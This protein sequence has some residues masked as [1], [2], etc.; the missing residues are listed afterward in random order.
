MSDQ[1]PDKT[2]RNILA[3]IAGAVTGII[4]YCI[5]AY[6]FFFIGLSAWP[7]KPTQEEAATFQSSGI[8][9]II[10]ITIISSLVAGLVTS[11]IAM[12]KKITVAAITGFV[13]M[14]AWL[15]ITNLKIYGTLDTVVILILIPS[16]ILGGWL[17]VNYKKKKAASN[18]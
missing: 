14:L 16:A 18:S 11:I 3:V 7:E 4:V 6:I 8:I 17:H 10:L 9:G 13:L 5:L 1:T 12:G 2:F 15:L